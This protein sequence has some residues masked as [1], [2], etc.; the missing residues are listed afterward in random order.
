MDFD[1]FVESTI[2]SFKGV[3]DY[4]YNKQLFIELYETKYGICDHFN[5]TNPLA[6]VQFNE[7]E[8]YLSNTLYEGYL[9]TF[10]YRDLGKKLHMSFDDFIARPRHEI[11]MMLRV[12]EEADKKKIKMNEGL[13]QD[14]ERAKDKADNVV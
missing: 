12:I 10:I 8:D 6:A 5:S 11:E 7:S 14:L 13:T 2:K 9:N 4:F 1:A 3:H